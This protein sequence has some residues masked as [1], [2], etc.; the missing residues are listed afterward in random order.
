VALLAHNVETVPRIFK[1]IRPGFRYDRSLAV[2]TAA[3]AAGL[4]TKSNLILGMGEE[5]EEISPGAAGPAR[6]RLR[7]HH[8]HAVPAPVAAPP[9]GDPLGRSRGVRGAG[10]EAEDIGFAGVM[11]GPARAL[12]LPRRPPLRAGRCA[13]VGHRVAPAWQRTTRD[14]QLPRLVLPQLRL[15]YAELASGRE[16][17]HAS[18]MPPRP[19]DVGRNPLRVTGGCTGSPGGSCSMAGHGRGAMSTLDTAKT[20]LY[21]HFRN[22]LRPALKASPR[23]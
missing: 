5:R 21:R 4:V 14:R 1:S 8:H 12:V 10:A 9:S 2:I 19:A 16:V 18:L 7:A 23:S 20:D 22:H 3:R 11:S 6:R 15:D 17:Q 13:P